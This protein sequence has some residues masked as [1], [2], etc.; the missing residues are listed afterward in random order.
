MTR[1]W[2]K[3]GS[4]ELRAT[5]PHE[6]FLDSSA[7]HERR[8]DDV[9]QELLR[10]QRT[11][12]GG[13][14]FASLFMWAQRG[15]LKHNINRGRWKRQSFGRQLFTGD[16]RAENAYKV[17]HSH[18]TDNMNVSDYQDGWRHWVKTWKKMWMT[19]RKVNANEDRRQ[20]AA[21]V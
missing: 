12:I 16:G 10:E 5:C 8:V 6:I 4:V 9:V 19:K 11:R 13:E 14:R 3:D 21:N 18:G 2:S 15:A 7:P 20:M 17:W 1:M